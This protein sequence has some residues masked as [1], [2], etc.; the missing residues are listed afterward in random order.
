MGGGSL[1]LSLTAISRVPS[2]LGTVPDSLQ[3]QILP[4]VINK[5]MADR[6]TDQPH[7]D[8]CNGM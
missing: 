2:T 4:D 3:N 7:L 1:S 8:F 6:W 5:W